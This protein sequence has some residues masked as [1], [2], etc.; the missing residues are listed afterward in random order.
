MAQ[1]LLK[2]IGVPESLWNADIDLNSVQAKITV[3]Q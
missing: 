3:G 1:R 2:I